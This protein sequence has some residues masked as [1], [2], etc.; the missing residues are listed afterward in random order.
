MCDSNHV[1]D[2]AQIISY[3]PTATAGAG[4]TINFPLCI[5]TSCSP[6]RILSYLEILYIHIYVYDTEQILYI[7]IYIYDTEQSY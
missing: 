7:R 2:R 4:G 3:Q 6:C 1:I 5:M